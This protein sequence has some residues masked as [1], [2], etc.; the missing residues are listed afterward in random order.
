MHVSV[1]KGDSNTLGDKPNWYNTFFFRCIPPQESFFFYCWE[2]E[3]AS[4]F[5]RSGI[6]LVSFR[7][8]IYYLSTVRN[9]AYIRTHAASIH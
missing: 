9:G 6:F 1:L 7:I 2:W 5:A 4:F 8:P 3:N